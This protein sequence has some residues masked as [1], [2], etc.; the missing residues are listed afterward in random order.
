MRSLVQIFCYTGGVKPQPSYSMASEARACLADKSGV[1]TALITGK[2]E[3]TLFPGDIDAYLPYLNEFF[4]IIELQTNAINF[5]QRRDE[6][7][8]M[9]PGSIVLII[10]HWSKQSGF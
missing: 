5:T 6:F 3:P 7:T 4:P 10:L 9:L 2:G 8:V 1:T